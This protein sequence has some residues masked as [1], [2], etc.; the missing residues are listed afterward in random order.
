MYI[1]ISVS[2]PPPQGENK[3]MRSMN[4]IDIHIS[5]M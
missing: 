1:D 4:F 3:P 2:V 5:N